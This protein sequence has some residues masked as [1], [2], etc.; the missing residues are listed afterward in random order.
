MLFALF[1][2]L[3]LS[4]SHVLSLGAA[5]ALN[6][7]LARKVETIALQKAETDALAVELHAKVSDRAGQL[8]GILS[9]LHSRADVAA[10]LEPGDLVE[11]RYRVERLL[12][13]GGMGRVYEVS[14]I[15]DGSRWAMKV[16][17]GLHGAALSRLA[18][19]AFL[20]TKIKHDNVVKIR[21]I[22]VRASGGLLVVM[23]L[24]AGRDLRAWLD[25][26][27]ARAATLATDLVRQL[28]SG[29]AALHEVGIAHRDLKPENL[30]IIEHEGVLRLKIVDFGIS[31]FRAEGSALD[32]PAPTPAAAASAADDDL[33]WG[34][35]G[36]VAPAPA[37][38]AAS[39]PRPGL[40]VEGTPHYMAPE[41]AQGADPGDL[42]ADLWSLGVIAYELSH[43]HRPFD[44]PPVIAL[45]RGGSIP[46]RAEIHLDEQPA[47]RDI[48]VRSLS[49]DPA[50][51]PEAAE[52]V[53]L[54]EGSSGLKRA[55]AR[56]ASRA[57]ARS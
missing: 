46:S 53:R 41:L 50:R 13:R 9:L 22:D 16:P 38:A 42:R 33:D 29:L 6:E 31:T 36:A 20:A 51:R 23:E 28:A 26:D 48:I 10:D 15:S 32:A 25:E 14:R 55:E 5:S 52:V 24:L 45:A 54:L 30:M 37:S 39:G 57:T 27:R 11:D 19:E 12:G 21:D 7:E 35:T 44:A 2:S 43:G 3:V 47:L 1:L 4:R 18:R 8:I 40:A 49:L 17:T 34:A 56:G